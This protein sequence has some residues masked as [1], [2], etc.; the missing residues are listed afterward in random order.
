MLLLLAGAAA[1]AAEGSA[2]VTGAQEA[3]QGWTDQEISLLRSLWVG[4]LPP[5]P[6][7]PSNAYSDNAKAADLGRKIFFDSRFSANGSV[8]CATCH[9]PEL[10]FTDPLP[11]AHGLA[12][13]TRRTM[14]LIGLAYQSWFFWDGRKDSLW[15]QA[16]APV[17]NP[18][19]HGFARSTCARLIDE[20]YRR[21]YEEIFGPISHFTDET[22]PPGARPATDDPVADA[23]WNS[24]NLNVRNE[25]NR[26]Y[27]NMGKAIG[28]FVRLIVPTPSR[29]DRAVE[30]LLRGD[31]NGMEK[32]LTKEEL[33]GL[34]LF[35]GKAKCV[36]CHNGP[37]LTNGDFHNVGVPRPSDLPPDRG[38]ADAIGLVRAD[39]FNCLGKY[40]DAGPKDCAELRFMD[41]AKER[42]TGAFK[43]PSLRNVADRPPYMHA[44]QI[45]TIRDVLLHYRGLK[46]GQGGVDHS[47][48]HGNLTDDELRQ[49]EAFLKTLSS[50]LT[51][52]S[53][54][55]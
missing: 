49:I 9:R 22:C 48:G 55:S 43:T 28:A 6:K 47:V 33:Q 41:T 44:G 10:G 51:H 34:R 1:W 30:S 8:S 53:P 15:S 3:R 2:P 14:P 17:E 11:R 25:V 13:T 18:L 29:F 38:R 32:G 35:I 5:L 31:G 16:L 39:E 50:P 26:I 40:S 52:P 19:E 23:L 21:E 45:S 20:L 36:N 42:Y 12:T 4:S 54:P 24:M 27:A 46:P 7:D 37:L